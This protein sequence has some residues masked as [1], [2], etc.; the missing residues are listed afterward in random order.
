MAPLKGELS[1]KLTE[2]SCGSFP[3]VGRP[4]H[5][6]AVPLPIQGRLQR[7]EK[8]YGSTKPIFLYTLRSV[9][10]ATLAAFSAP[11]L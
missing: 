7:G 1:A 8:P 9:R 4:L 3:F 5:R 11:D 6:Y 2:G 10:L